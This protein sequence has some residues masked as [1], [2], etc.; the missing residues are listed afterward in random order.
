[1]LRLIATGLGVQEPLQERLILPA[2]VQRASQP[3]KI[4]I[5]HGQ[6]YPVRV[7][8]MGLAHQPWQGFM[9]FEIMQRGRKKALPR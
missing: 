5:R 8:K 3:G 2:N 4:L 7:D 9:L 1:M 6:P